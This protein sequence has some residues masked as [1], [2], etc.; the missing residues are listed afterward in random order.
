MRGRDSGRRSGGGRGGSNAGWARDLGLVIALV[1]IT[2]LVLFGVDAPEAVV[3]LL[4]VPFLLLLPGYAVISAMFPEDSGRI[5]RTEAAQPWHEP[6][7]LVRI[8]LSLV[9]SAVVLSVVGVALSLASAISRGPVVVAVSSVTIV[10]V[11]VAAVRRLQV[12]PAER[13]MPFGD[14]S[15]VW[16]RLSSGSSVQTGAA[17]AALLVLAAM[18]AVTGAAPSEGEAYTEFYVLSEGEDGNLTAAEF[19]QEFTSGEGE[20]LYVGLENREHEPTSYEVVMLAQAV[21]DDGSVVIQQQVDRF[22]ARLAHGEN[23]TF[24]RNVAP[25][26]VG[27]EV[28]LQIL[29]YKGEAP[30]NPSADTADQSLQIWI[31]V[32]EG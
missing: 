31:D 25:T 11:A 21:D 15:R 28:R 32:V 5:Q 16:G 8:G 3:W 6:D 2:N 22:D 13:A 14:D 30:D 24:E 1:A 26:L 27:E 20:T 18:L 10:A 17:V 12:D 23:E 19:P 9:T 29:L 4:G 7:Y